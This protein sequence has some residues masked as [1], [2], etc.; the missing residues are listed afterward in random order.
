MG[1]GS[2][3][4]C[5]RVGHPEGARL[6]GAGF[7]EEGAETHHAPQNTSRRTGNP[8]DAVN[9]KHMQR[10]RSHNMALVMLGPVLAKCSATAA[11]VY[12]SV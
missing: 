12:G 6:E 7:T 11:L 5:E 8:H 9:I 10:S 3:W 4:N 1:K 2:T